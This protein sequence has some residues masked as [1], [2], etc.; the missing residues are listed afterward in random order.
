MN[1]KDQLLEAANQW[2]HATGNT[3]STL[4][5]YVVNDGKFFD[6]LM[7][8]GGFTDATYNKVMKWLEDSNTTSAPPAVAVD[9]GSDTRA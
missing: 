6:R 4:G 1:L 7:S 9:E 5:N 3:L 8:G 2:C